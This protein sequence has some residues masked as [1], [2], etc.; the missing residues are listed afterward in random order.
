LKG[1][2]M[3]FFVVL[4]GLHNGVENSVENVENLDKSVIYKG[5]NMVMGKITQQHFRGKWNI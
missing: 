1:T 4:Q 3:G 2:E 5:G